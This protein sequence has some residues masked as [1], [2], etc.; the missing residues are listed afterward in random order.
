MSN[1]FSA[2]R[3][4]ADTMAVFE[5]QLTVSQNNVANASTP[6]Y[7][8]QQLT[9][10]AL[11][12]DSAGGAQGGVKAG[13]VE[14]A[15]D[16]YAEK[17]V[18]TQLS[19]L[20]QWEQQVSALTPLDSSFDLSGQ[21]GIPGALNQLF[22]SFSAWSASPT[23]TTAR[24]AV[25]NAAQ[26]VAQAFQQTGNTL[27]QASADAGSQL[28]SLTTQINTLAGQ[29]RQFNV[30]RTQGGGVDPSVDAGM[31]SALEQLSEIAPISTLQQPDGSMTVLLAGQTP[32]VVGAFQ[33]QI[34]FDNTAPVSST[35]AY[36]S[37][38]PSARLLDASGNDI[39]SQVTSGQLGGLLNVRNNLLPTLLGDTSQ[40]GSLNQLAQTIADRVNTVL[41]S[42][43]ISDGP[44]PVTGVPLF[45]YDTTNLTTA[46]QTLAVD[47]TVTAG[48]LAAI[49]PGPPE[50]SNGIPNEL[51][52][53][54]SPQDPANMIGNA[55]Y[56]QYF[57]GLAATVGNALS[58]AQNN[59]SVQ[60][61]LVTQAR[62]LRQQ[63]SGV[64]LDSEA[65]TV[66]Q[67][68][69]SYDAAAKMV[70]ILDEMTQTVV[71]MIS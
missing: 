14:T 46:A 44:P 69:R 61:N 58:T 54:A 71:N 40:Q 64:S 56:M 17:A 3:A 26:S 62:N 37:G 39:T 10:E 22:Q 51:A 49:A 13:P 25:L 57:G 11:P 34:S 31:Y 18:Q 8:R 41:T 32:L 33:Y 21:S 45:T 7:A 28:G 65:V 4:S 67:F 20:G 68:Q 24:Q 5:Q 52:D 12:F 16:V 38:P 59:Q 43:N 63:T 66:L 47:P 53:M 36:P 1:L 30:D 48:Q 23:D 70:T 42:G 27:A 9:L 15:R 50:V 19:S 29:I 2:L 55:S 35:A 60:Q 6:G